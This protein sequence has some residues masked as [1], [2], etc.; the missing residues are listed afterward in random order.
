MK[1]IIASVILILAFG[2]A[3]FAQENSCPQI[4]VIGPQGL[5]D[6]EGS[7]Q[8]N[9]EINRE[10]EKYEPEYFW[11]V[12][13]GKITRGQG[14]PEIEVAT[15]LE[16]AGSNINVT[17]K[18]KGLPE[19]C[20]DSGSEYIVIAARNI[21][22]WF[23]MFGKLPENT[24]YARIDNYLVA[25]INDWT[26]QGVITLEFDKTETRAKKIKRLNRILAHINRRKFDKSRLKFL[27]SETAEEYTKLYIIPQ[28]KKISD[29]LSESENYQI[30][31][32]EEI[33][34]EIKKIF[35]KK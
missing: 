17:V 4:N 3:S 15:G 18:L 23:D 26:A 2:V 8:L 33:E 16:D 7:A 28:D 20:P 34:R 30:I 19:N 24:V 12:S 25:L 5:I 22:Y 10:I 32:G 21:H 11:T 14:T 27:I 35:P 9:V 13:S 6:I 29:V 31:K 1:Q